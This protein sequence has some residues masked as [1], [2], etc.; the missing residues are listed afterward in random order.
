M[1][2]KH[3]ILQVED[4]LE[5]YEKK[6]RALET[7]SHPPDP[8]DPVRRGDGSKD[9]ATIVVAAYNSH[10][11]G[12][13]RADF[14]VEEGQGDHLTEDNWNNPKT[15]AFDIIQLAIDALPENGGRIILLEGDYYHWN[16]VDLGVDSLF[17]TKPN[18]EIV[19]MGMSTRIWTKIPIEM[20][21]DGIRIAHLYINGSRP[22]E[23]GGAQDPDPY[24]RWGIAGNSDRSSIDHVHVHGAYKGIENYGAG[25][26][27]GSRVTNCWVTDCTERGIDVGGN[28]IISDCHILRCATW[29][30]M[31]A[32]RV[33]GS[34]SRI[35]NCTVKDSATWEDGGYGIDFS[36]SEGVVTNCSVTGSGTTDSIRFTSSESVL[37]D[38]FIEG[39][40]GVGVHYTGTNPEIVNIKVQD[41]D[42]DGFHITGSQGHLIGCIVDGCNGEHGYHITGSEIKLIGCHLEDVGSNIV[43][44]ILHTGSEAA[45]IGC[46]LRGDFSTSEIGIRITG[47]G[48]TIAHTKI[49][50]FVEDGIQS[51]GSYQDISNNFINFIGKHGIYH[52]GTDSII[53]SN[54]INDCGR[55]GIYINSGNNIINA[56]HIRN[57]SG[58]TTLTYSGIYL[59]FSTG[60]ETYCNIQGNSIRDLNGN[61]LYGIHVSGDETFVTNNDLKD[62]GTPGGLNDAGTG[63]YTAPGNRV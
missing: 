29:G 60:T 52:T 6:F 40:L 8:T 41:S 50:G 54:Y 51:T 16:A 1:R 53:N 55:H 42:G 10:A 27:I 25:G 13:A 5:D 48:S 38:C 63:T 23:V 58:E 44:G 28:M 45:I 62:S 32:L 15:R 59:D 11:T 36:G 26:G 19:G 31:Y 39:A 20:A 17:I 37:G 46:N 24:A 9:W 18:V 33:S 30:D 56:N 49:E 3:G 34:Y 2:P 21:A 4:L 47:S 35:T 7:H 43:E 61:Q 22:I 57:C 12:K 14:V